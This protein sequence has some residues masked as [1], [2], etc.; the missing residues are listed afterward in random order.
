VIALGIAGCNRSTPKTEPPSQA[1]SAAPAHAAL[2][3]TPG[4]PTRSLLSEIDQAKF[5]AA[6][7]VHTPAGEGSG[8]VLPAEHE[9]L[10]HLHAVLG[11]D[12][13]IASPIFVD[14]SLSP[15]HPRNHLQ[16]YAVAQDPTHDLVLLKVGRPPASG[17]RR[18][19][20]HDRRHRHHHRGSGGEAPDNG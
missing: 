17:A 1:G 2:A 9:V 8:L 3:E 7:Q 6:A 10:A 11:P 18:A 4:L 15:G 19:D 12:K 14:L 16:A 20:G 5:G 13:Q